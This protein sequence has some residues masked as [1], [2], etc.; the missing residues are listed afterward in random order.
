MALGESRLAA[1]TPASVTRALRP[2]PDLRF[3]R[4]PFLRTYSWGVCCQPPAHA[5]KCRV[6]RGQGSSSLYIEVVVVSNLYPLAVNYGNR[7]GPFKRNR[8]G[9]GM[10]E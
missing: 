7:R 1:S 6:L 4:W 10:V 8:D 2:T 5:P 3:L 9:G